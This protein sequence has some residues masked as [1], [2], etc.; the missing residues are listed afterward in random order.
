M[1]PTSPKVIFPLLPLEFDSECSYG[2][3]LGIGM[4]LESSENLQVEGIFYLK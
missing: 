2:I 4:S 1:T 3:L